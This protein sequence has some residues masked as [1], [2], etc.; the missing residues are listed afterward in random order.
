[1]EISGEFPPGLDL[2]VGLGKLIALDRAMCDPLN[3]ITSL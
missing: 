3:H 2:S 1:M